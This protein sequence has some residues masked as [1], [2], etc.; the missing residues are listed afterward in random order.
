MATAP[1]IGCVL[2]TRVWTAL[3]VLPALLAIII[4]AP[5]PLFAAIIAILALIALSEIAAMTAARGAGR[6][7]LLIVAAILPAAAV[8]LAPNAFMIVPEL[9]VLGLVLMMAL[10]WVHGAGHGPHGAS[11]IAIGGVYVGAL[12]PYFVLLRNGADGVA[13]TILMLLLVIATDSAAYF[14]GRAIGRVKLAPNVSPNKTV[15]G[16]IGGLL[17]ALAAGLALRPLLVPHWEM[18]AAVKV[19]I[20]VSILAQAGDLVGSTLKRAAGVKDS[21]WI[22]PGHG[23]LIDRCC[24]LVFA[25]TFT[26]YYSR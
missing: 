4:F 21:G 20:V 10:M 7:T 26:Y 12:F 24:S 17:A 1:V 2:R 19:A 5:G 18:I 14:V 15:E 11:L 13:L 9:T 23:G 16:A 8:Y 6:L 3:A 22:F 25:V